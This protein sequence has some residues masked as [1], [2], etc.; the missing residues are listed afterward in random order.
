[1]Y[2]ID[3]CNVEGMAPQDTLTAIMK[4]IDYGVDE[5]ELELMVTK[6]HQV[7]LAKNSYIT[8]SDNLNLK[9][10]DHSLSELK[11]H[12]REITTLSQALEL[13][14]NKIKLCVVFK[15]KT[16]LYAIM[17]QLQ[18]E[19]KL[20]TK[21]QNI[22]IASADFAALSQIKKTLPGFSY[23]VNES[24]SGV[25]ARLR[26]NKL[27]TKRLNMSAKWLWRGYVTPLSKQGYKIYAYT[28]NDPIKAGKMIN[29]GLAGIFTDQPDKF[30]NVK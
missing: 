29:Y 1:M 30:L 12:R 13:T 23:A 26:A 8:G 18:D 19:L 28:I 22:T 16:E 6:D 15:P 3:R 2:I 20:N 27:G 25:R 14:R 21:P 10:S 7:V 11:Q 4:A 5:I 9:I 24:W 17:K